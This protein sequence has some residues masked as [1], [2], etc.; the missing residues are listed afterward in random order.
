MVDF[1]ERTIVEVKVALAKSLNAVSLG[2]SIR[3]FLPAPSLSPASEGAFCLC[4]H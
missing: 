1:G 2:H 3:D 4:S